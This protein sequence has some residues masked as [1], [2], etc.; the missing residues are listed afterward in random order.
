MVNLSFSDKELEKLREY[1]LEELEKARQ[2]VDEI[3][4]ILDKIGGIPASVTKT[5]PKS[6]PGGSA[7]SSVT[8]EPG[9]EKKT[10]A[11]EGF[12]E[13]IE[14]LDK[15][16]AEEKQ[17]ARTTKKAATAKS[18][19]AKPKTEETPPAKIPKVTA[20]FMKKGVKRPTK[21][22]IKA[23]RDWTPQEWEDSVITV[24]TDNPQLVAHQ[25]AD[26]V[27]N[28]YDLSGD[29]LVDAPEMVQRQLDELCRKGI[30]FAYGDNSAEPMFGLKLKVK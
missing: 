8:A 5:E 30:L 14:I 16:E 22:K 27:I 1:F 11:K 24:V 28:R 20:R 13:L 4:G 18:A 3:R 2:Q 6:K 26:E 10:G 29:N 9:K 15:S 12:A 21:I 19:A 25:I 23:K 17:A 7:K